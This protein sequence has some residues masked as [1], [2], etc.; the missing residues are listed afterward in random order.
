MAKTAIKKPV[1]KKSERVEALLRIPLGIICYIIVYVWG[2]LAGLLAVFQ[3]FYVI[4]TGKKNKPVSNFNNQF[5]TFAYTF[6]RYIF[7]TTNERPFPFADF[8]KPFDK[9]E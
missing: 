1:K 8:K 2:A 7:F 5:V 6:G 4:I 3:F 9:I